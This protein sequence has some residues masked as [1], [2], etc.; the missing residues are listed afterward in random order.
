MK[1]IIALML[2]FC[3]LYATPSLAAAY[4]WKMACE[5]IAGSVSDLYAQEFA[6]LLKE[7]SNGDIQLD[8]FHHGTLG[9]PTEMFELTLNGA[10]EFALV[11]PGQSSSIVPENQIFLL[12][13]LFSNDDDLNEKFLATSK[14]LNEKLNSVYEAKGLKVLGYFS[15]GSMYWTAN[16]PIASPEDFKGLKFRVMP[17]EL[18]VEVYKAYGANPTPVSFN[19]VYSG[20]QLKMIEGQE[21]AP[22]IIQEM[23]FMDVQKNLI[24]SKHNIYVMHNLVNLDFFKKLPEDVKKILLEATAEVRPFIDTVQRDLNKERLAMMLKDFK[25]DQKL[26]EVT[27]ENF[28]AFREAAKEADRKYLELSRNPEF[29]KDLL[30]QFREE[31]AEIESGK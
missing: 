12:H 1:K 19:E 14:A 22:Y 21:N 28:K 24:A 31:M 5:E 8:I 2:V 20:L 13:F 30:E 29:A 11:G 18:L 6:R 4:Q 16:K 7:K 9:T 17:S 15:E 10:V 3:A 25:A 27:P 23:K 26:L